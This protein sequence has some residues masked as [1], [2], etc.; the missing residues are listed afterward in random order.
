M[1]HI[2][3]TKSSLQNT[4]APFW[5]LLLF[6]SSTLLVLIS[7]IN[8]IFSNRVTSGWTIH[9]SLAFCCWSFIYAIASYKFFRTIY[10]FTT[11][12]ILCLSVFHL[13]HILS[14]SLGILN[15]PHLI[16]GKMAIYY[17]YAGWYSI[18]A[19]GGMGIG[20]SLSSKKIKK[21]TTFSRQKSNDKNSLSA[22]YWIGFGLFAFSCAAL[23]YTFTKVGNILNYSRAQ[24]F[25]GIGD[26]R[27]FGFFLLVMPSAMILLVNGANTRKQKIFV[28]PLSTI[29][30]LILLFLGYRSSALF[31]AMIG[32]I[33]WIKLGRRISTTV[34]ICSLTF[35]LFSIPTVRYLRALGPYKNI[36]HHDVIQSVKKS[37]LIDIVG[38][39]GGT[40]AIIA[41]VLKWVPNEE[42]YR[43]GSSYFLAIKNSLPNFGLH[44][45]ESNRKKIKKSGRV[46]KQFLKKMTPSDW[47]VY[48]TNKYMFNIGGGSGF[49]TIAEAYLNFGILG[50]LIYFIVLGFLLGKIDQISLISHPKTLIFAGTMLW[51]LL[52]TVRNTSGTFFKP[53]SFVIVTI[54]VW[55]ICTFW[56]QRKTGSLLTNENYP[57][58]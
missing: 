17:Q 38:E 26:L 19:L 49:S 5:I 47:F 55:K 28:Y 32:A 53:L 56:I 2:T 35:V 58:H 44:Q 34:L 14:H 16:A 46:D 8:I 52:K 10:L 51:P 36:S 1:P 39:L 27:G 3:S 18:L 45:Q 54:L 11:A 40:S 30:F 6:F 50:V 13:S 4:Q 31:S 57:H 15:F 24:L 25:G 20:V 7:L 42:S 43:Y 23:L 48:R 37:Q 21:H 41:Y 9:V 22:A 33:L 12:Y 29:V